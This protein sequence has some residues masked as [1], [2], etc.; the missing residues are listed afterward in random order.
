MKYRELFNMI[1]YLGLR[2]N[3]EVFVMEGGKRY[4][5][6]GIAKY[7]NEKLAFGLVQIEETD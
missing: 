6:K 2:D 7:G 1:K 5:I 4:E 3:D